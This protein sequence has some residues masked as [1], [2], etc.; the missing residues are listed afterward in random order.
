M[1]QMVHG[2]RLGR[3]SDEDAETT[4]H[5]GQF[6]LEEDASGLLVAVKNN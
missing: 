3:A 1:A 5:S 4:D 6:P 2:L